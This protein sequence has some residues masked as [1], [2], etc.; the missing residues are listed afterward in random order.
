MLFTSRIL[1][2]TRRPLRDASPRG[3]TYK[4]SLML[5]LEKKIPFVLGE[6]LIV[7]L[8][9]P[10]TSSEAC[11]DFSLSATKV[12]QEVTYLWTVTKNEVRFALRCHSVCSYILILSFSSVTILRQLFHY[13]AC[14]CNRK[15]AFSQELWRN[16]NVK[17][18]SHCQKCIIYHYKWPLYQD[19]Q[20]QY[21][22]SRQELL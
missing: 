16:S 10:P 7:C 5:Q 19:W 22:S 4:E 15:T 13:F 9:Y 11:F 14:D 2:P 20:C 1:S 8:G 17:L 6:T 21:N 3:M 12:L 18:Q